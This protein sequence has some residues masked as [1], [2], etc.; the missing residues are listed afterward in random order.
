MKDVTE[1]LGFVIQCHLDSI[2]LQL[3]TL[4]RLARSLQEATPGAKDEVIAVS[5]VVAEVGKYF[6]TQEALDRHGISTRFSG[7][8]A[9]EEARYAAGSS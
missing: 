8:K 1:S 4:K 3:Q 9:L 7:R 2:Q 6:G 5:G